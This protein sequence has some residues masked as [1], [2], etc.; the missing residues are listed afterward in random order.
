MLAGM[1]PRINMVA[2][3]YPDLK[4]NTNFLNLEN[5]LVSLKTKSPT[6]VSST[7]ASTSFNKAIE[8]ILDIV[9]GIKDASDESCGPLRCYPRERSDFLSTSGFPSPWSFDVNVTRHRRS[10]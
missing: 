1:I 2:E 9:A 7:T 10:R 3:Q 4:A 6:D 8:M 5:Q